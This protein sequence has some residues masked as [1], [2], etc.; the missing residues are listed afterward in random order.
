MIR[1]VPAPLCGCYNRSAWNYPGMYTRQYLAN[2]VALMRPW[3]ERFPLLPVLPRITDT[4]SW[5]SP[6]ETADES[7]LFDTHGYEP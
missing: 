7:H 6:C 5:F 3:A 4:K 2:I 1:R